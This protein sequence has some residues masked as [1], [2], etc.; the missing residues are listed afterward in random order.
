M[1]FPLAADMFH[2]VTQMGKDH[3]LLFGPSGA[4]AQ[5]YGLFDTALALG[6]MFGPAFAGLLYEKGGWNVAVWGLAV[7][8]SSGVVPV[9]GLLSIFL[10]NS[11]CFDCSFLSRLSTK[12]RAEAVHWKVK[13]E[14]EEG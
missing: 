12:I 4:Y 9:V 3:Y 6:V 5:A 14:D 2:I 7:F 8:C 1:L 11:K 10:I 13:K